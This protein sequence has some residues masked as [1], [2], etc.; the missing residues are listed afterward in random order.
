MPDFYP[1]WAEPTYKIVRLLI[2]V[3]TA[4]VIFPYLPW[5]QSPAFRGI[6]MFLGVL[7]SLGSTSAVANIVVGVILTYVRA[8]TL[9][10]RVQ[11]ADT[12]GDIL[13]KTL[14]VAERICSSVIPFG[15]GHTRATI[16]W[17]CKAGRV[18]FSARPSN[19][20]RNSLEVN[21]AFEDQ[22]KRSRCHHNPEKNSLQQRSRAYFA[23]CLC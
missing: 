16:Q 18:S 23:D 8:F 22:G 5:A 7:L 20:V 21:P 3:L 14:L 10:D 12:T 6:S 4:V 11:I 19:P 1:E 17:P 15:T 2:L 13:E 9:G